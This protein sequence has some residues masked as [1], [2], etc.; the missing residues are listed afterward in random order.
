[1]VILHSTQTAGF[2]GTFHISETARIDLR[3]Q[4]AGLLALSD[5]TRDLWACL[6]WPEDTPAADRRVI[7]NLGF[8]RGYNAGVVEFI[9]RELVQ[10]GACR[11]QVEHCRRSQVRHRFAVDLRE[12]MEQ[13]AGVLA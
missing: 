2:P 10:A 12:A 4:A 13:A 6:E 3:A 7:L 11:V 9:A 8:I 1:M 5:L